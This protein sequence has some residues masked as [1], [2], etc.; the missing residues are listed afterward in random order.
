MTMART[1]KLYKLP[2]LP[3]TPGIRPLEPK[4]VPQV[5]VM[6]NKYLSNFRL[7]QVFDEEEV[8]HW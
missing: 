7:T 4:D 3:V 8:A 6:L 1:I 5:T 2:D